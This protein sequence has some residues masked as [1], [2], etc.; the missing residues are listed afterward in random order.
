MF[1]IHELEP[2]DDLAGKCSGS[3]CCLASTSASEGFR[4]DELAEPDDIAGKCS[5]SSC[6]LAYGEPTE[7]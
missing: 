2:G 7:S 4:V 5:G 1:E 6:C 3:S